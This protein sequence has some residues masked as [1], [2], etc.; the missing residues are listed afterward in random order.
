MEQE[1]T[2][3]IHHG[4]ATFSFKT[5]RTGSNLKEAIKVIKE[6]VTSNEHLLQSLEIGKKAS[7]SR[8][9]LVHTS[10]SHLTLESLS[11]S[12]EL[13]DK[14]VSNIRSISRL[15]LVIILLHHSKGLTY[16][17]LMTLSKELGKPIIYSW[18]NTHFQRKE[19]REFIRSEPI[20]ESQEK[21]YSLTEP[22]KKEAERIIREI[23]NKG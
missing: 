11:L 20:P 4:N 10:T 2:I 18:L 22:G 1:I 13:K 7:A 8:S 15:D 16:D 19:R 12:S 9:I 17:N 21:L 6:I 3:G 5:D 23:N 14:I